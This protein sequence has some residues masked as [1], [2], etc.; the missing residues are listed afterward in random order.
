MS[1]EANEPES[2]A[3]AEDVT[4]EALLSSTRL[5]M[6]AEE[7]RQLAETVTPDMLGHAGLAEQLRSVLHGMGEVLDGHAA[8]AEA[9]TREMIERHNDGGEQ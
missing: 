9:R 1:G 3:T 5:S 2:A 4:D 8:V 6:Y 7:T